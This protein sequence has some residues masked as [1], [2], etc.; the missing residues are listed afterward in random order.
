VPRMS[1]DDCKAMLLA[2]PAIEVP[3]HAV[4]AVAT[5]LAQITEGLPLHAHYSVIQLES[6]SRQRF[7]M[8][9]VLDQL[10]PYGGDLEKYYETIWQTFGPETK[11]LAIVFAV[12]EFPVPRA[13]MPAVF[14]GTATELQRAIE[15]LTPFVNETLQGLTLF[16]ASFQEFVS[17]HADTV[18]YR[19]ASLERL[20]QWLRLHA[21]PSLRWRWL[22]A[23][24]F[25]A[26]NSQPLIDSTNREWIIDSI[27]DGQPCTFL[28]VHDDRIS[29]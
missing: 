25:E 4:D 19:A 17:D 13:A 10:V 28:A 27:K 16:H 7:I 22:H 9:D 1:A 12:S 20:I 8:E 24:E 15:M 2:H 23:K 6:L 29:L 21:K 18:M 3:E 26:G 11:I 5:R 14:N